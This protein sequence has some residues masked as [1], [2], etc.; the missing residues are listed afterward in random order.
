MSGNKCEWCGRFGAQPMEHT[1]LGGKSGKEKLKFRSKINFCS[2]KCQSEYGDRFNIEYKKVSGC[3]IATAAYSDFNH[4]VV[5]DLREFRDNYLENRQWG[6]VFIKKYYIYSP[7][8]AQIISHSNFLKSATR[9][10]LIPVH[11][12]AKRL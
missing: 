3:F 2:R 5:L 10:I 6:R 4:P 1:T 12:I 8:L 9:C 7:K 11:F